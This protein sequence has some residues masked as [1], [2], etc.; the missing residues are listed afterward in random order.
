MLGQNP[1]IQWLQKTNNKIRVL[2]WTIQPK[3]QN[4][5]QNS[6]ITVHE[7]A[8][9]SP[10]YSLHFANQ[11][12]VHSF[13]FRYESNGDYSAFN[14]K[15]VM[16][17]V[18]KLPSL[19]LTDYMGLGFAGKGSLSDA[20]NNNQ[21]AQL[22]NNAYQSNSL[23]VYMVS[24]AG[25]N[26]R[27]NYDDRLVLRFQRSS[28]YVYRQG[29]TT[30]DTDPMQGKIVSLNRSLIAIRPVNPKAPFNDPIVLRWIYDSG[31][32]KAEVMSGQE[33]PDYNG[34]TIVDVPENRQAFGCKSWS[35]IMSGN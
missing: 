33:Y 34:Y 18:E 21:A 15:K 30:C 23:Y 4:T 11:T 27:L 26:R 28:V 6:I 32:L 31:K 5:Y 7:L 29:K 13:P 16:I 17:S 2:T 22:V 9:D 3:T 1:C 14:G 8:L 20:Q 12:Y 24:V 35:E 10:I 25:P 19:K